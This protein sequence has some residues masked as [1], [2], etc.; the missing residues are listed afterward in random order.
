M[1]LFRLSACVDH[2]EVVLFYLPAPDEF[3]E[4]V[5]VT[6]TGWGFQYFTF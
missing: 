1:A 5:E 2:R 6:W 4:P 3:V